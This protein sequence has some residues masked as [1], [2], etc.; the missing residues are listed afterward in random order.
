MMLLHSYPFTAT[1]LRIFVKWLVDPCTDAGERVVCLSA[2]I[3]YERDVGFSCP[4]WKCLILEA[5]L[6]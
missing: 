3:G 6:L 4:E 5:V 1:F 2:R